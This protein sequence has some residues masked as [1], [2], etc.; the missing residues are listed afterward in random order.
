MPPA[1]NF[2]SY[3]Q[4][5]LQQGNQPQQSYQQPAPNVPQYN[6]QGFG[7]YQQPSFQGQGYQ[8][9]PPGFTPLDDNGPL[10]F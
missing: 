5:Y 8:H 7:G 9:T 6:Q 3:P 4:A 2:G 10:P 1:N